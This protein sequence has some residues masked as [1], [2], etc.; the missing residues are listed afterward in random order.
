M[1][2]FVVFESSSRL[3]DDDRCIDALPDFL[4]PIFRGVQEHTGLHAMVILG[5]P[6]PKYAGELR[7]VKYVYAL[8]L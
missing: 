2:V 6:M 7:T 3:M 8:R 1:R 5:G 4:E